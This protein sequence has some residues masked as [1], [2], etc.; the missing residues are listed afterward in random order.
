MR[1]PRNEFDLIFPRQQI[2]VLDQH[3]VAVKENSWRQAH[4]NVALEVRFAE[5]F[6]VVGDP[7]GP[8]RRKKDELGIRAESL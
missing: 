1:N 7:I 5:C 3:T 6:E 2:D 8:K 4:D